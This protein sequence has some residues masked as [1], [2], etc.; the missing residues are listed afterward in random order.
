M[1][2]SSP[3][4]QFTGVA[5]RCLAVSC[6]ESSTRC[7]SSKSSC[8]HRIGD[9]ELDPLIGADHE[10]IADGLIV[11]S[12]APLRTRA[13][14]RRQHAVGFCDIQIGIPDHRIVRR[15]A[16]GLLDVLR[17]SGVI[18]HRVDRKRDDLG[19]TPIELRLEFRQIAEFGR[20]HQVKSLGCENSTA[21]ELPIQSCKRIRPSVVS[22]SKSGAKSLICSVIIHL[23]T[24]RGCWCPSVRTAHGRLARPRYPKIAEKRSSCAYHSIGEAD[25]DYHYGGVNGPPRNIGG[26][27][28][29]K[30]Y[31]IL[32]S[33]RLLDL[34][35][36]AV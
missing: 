12:G 15:I 14:T 5:T 19:V 29:P 21:Q 9:N 25:R 3:C 11:R 27:L 24:R 36:R 10:S 2:T 28:A 20:A 34:P 4:F 32:S 17:P 35:G 6:S 31:P 30:F 23:L 8:R 13:G 18:R 26:D 33:L 22:A 16:L 1:I 7:T